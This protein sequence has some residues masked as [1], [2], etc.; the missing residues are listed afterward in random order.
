MM[1][2][3]GGGTLFRRYLIVFLL[4]VG[5]VLVAASATELYFTYQETKRALVRVER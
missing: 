1:Q 3:R 4:L 5:G 2:P